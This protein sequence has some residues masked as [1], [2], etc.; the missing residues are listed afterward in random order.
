MNKDNKA[1]PAANALVKIWPGY[2][3]LVNKVKNSMRLY[4]EVKS[5]SLTLTLAP[6]PSATPSTKMRLMFSL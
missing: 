1:Q 3:S 4:P 6:E 5:T 2:A